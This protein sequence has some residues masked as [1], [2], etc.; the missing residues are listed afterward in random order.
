MSIFKTYWEIQ[1]IALSTLHP[2]QIAYE[3]AGYIEIYL[4][5]AQ[6]LTKDSSLLNKN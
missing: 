4:L 1:L 3:N 5:L 2:L 6:E